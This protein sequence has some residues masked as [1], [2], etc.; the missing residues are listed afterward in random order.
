M[1]L[2]GEK[3]S[4]NEL[5]VIRAWI[6]AGALAEGEDPE[7]ATK[8]LKAMQVGQ[9]EIFVNVFRGHFTTCQGKWKQEAGLDLQ[10]RAGLLKGEKSGTVIVPGKPDESL[11]YTLITT[12]KMPP[13]DVRGTP[14]YVRPVR[15]DDLE[16]L[17]D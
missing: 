6:A 11:V 2:G 15:A 14:H 17:R 4:A 7:T 1:P 13:R 12:D 10:T 5:E 9:R 16:N 8:N 3:L